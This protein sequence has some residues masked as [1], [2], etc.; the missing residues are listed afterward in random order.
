MSG[1][2]LIALMALTI[3]RDHEAPQGRAQAP[4]G[5]EDHAAQGRRADVRGGAEPAEED[6]APWL[7][8]S[9]RSRRR[10]RPIEKPAKDKAAEKAPKA[11]AAGKKRKVK[12]VTKNLRNQG[13]K[14]EKE[15]KVEGT[16]RRSTRNA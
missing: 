8:M 2:I 9:T 10:A 7:A 4:H 11:N 1:C 13:G 5:R 12:E 6:G 15:R 16:R 14:G 3:E